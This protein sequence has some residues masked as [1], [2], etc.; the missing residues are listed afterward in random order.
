M[1]Q[2]FSGLLAIMMICTAAQAQKIKTTSGSIDGLKNENTFNVEFTYDNLA[3]GKYKTEKEYVDSKKAERNAKEAG[4][5][6]KW[7][8]AWVADREKR[9]EPKFIDLF[10]K[11]ATVEISK[12]AKYTL[13]INTNFI[14]PGYNIAGGMMIGGRKN[15]QI[16][17][18]I[19]IVET[20][21]RSNVVATITAEKVPGG[22]FFGNDYDTGVRI[23]ESYAMLGKKLAKYIK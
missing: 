18:E 6:D 11:T 20:A 1:K 4:S 15:A 23:S 3:V 16:D 5:G 2:F 12:A 21:N 22:Q 19:K 9:F 13:I 7:A 8:E 10:T 14:E 17:T